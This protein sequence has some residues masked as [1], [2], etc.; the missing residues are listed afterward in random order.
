MLM[1]L[2][3]LSNFQLEFQKPLGDLSP[4]I[5]LNDLSAYSLIRPPLVYMETMDPGAACSGEEVV[6]QLLGCSLVIRFVAWLL[7]RVTILVFLCIPYYIPG[8][9]HSRR[10]CI[11]KSDD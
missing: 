10:Y 6:S 7:E 3:C 9:L 11:K 1:H 5:M 8:S 2:N 4:K